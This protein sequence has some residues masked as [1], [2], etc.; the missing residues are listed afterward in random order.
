MSD[1]SHFFAHMARLKLI[2]R[3]PLMRNTQIENVQEHSLQVAMIS[4][5]LAVI[6]NRFFDGSLNAAEI[7]LQALY[8]DASEV[9]TGDL[10][11]PIKYHNPEIAKEYKKIETAAEQRLL[12]MLPNELCADFEG[13]LIGAK[14]LPEHKLII[15]AADTLCAY[16]KCL[17][18]QNAGNS[19]FNQAK[20][21]LEQQLAQFALPEVDYFIRHFVASFNLTLDEIS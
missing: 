18:E 8:H 13:L 6:R 9:I 17:E 16:L 2:Q 14:Q 11:T 4:H 7:A 10:P 12:E 5:A 15:K 20:Q 21:R 1:N 19:E 3:W